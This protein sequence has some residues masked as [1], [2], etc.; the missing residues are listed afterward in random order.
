MTTPLFSTYSQGENRVTATFI[1][2]LQR[3]SLPIMDRILGELLGEQEETFNLITFINQ[4]QG[5]ESTPDAKIETGHGIWFETKIAPNAVSLDQTRRHM[6]AVGT[7]EKLVV[8]TPDDEKPRPVEK[9]QET[10]AV[11]PDSIYNVPVRRCSEAINL[12]RATH[13]SY[14]QLTYRAP[15]PYPEAIAARSLM[16]AGPGGPIPPSL[17]TAFEKLCAS[18]DM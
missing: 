3:L 7:D 9:A 2:V 4:P 16:T 18:A 5:I 8:L 11:V 13:Y 10:K 15:S 6:K 17:R 12:L 14:R 1:A